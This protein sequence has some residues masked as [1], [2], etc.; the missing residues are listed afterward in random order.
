MNLLID[1]GNSS[2]KIALFT[3]NSFIKIFRI[4][5]L[6]SK[7]LTAVLDESNP[8]SCIIAT[9]KKL[10]KS[11]YEKLRTINHFHELTHQSNLPLTIKY[12]SPNTLGKDR[13]AAAVGAQTIFPD[14]NVLVIDFGTAITYDIITK[15][16]LYIGGNIAPGLNTRFRSLHTETDQLP[17]LHQTESFPVIGNNTNNAIISGVQTGIVFEIEGYINF[18]RHNYKGFKVIFTGGDAPFFVKMIKTTIF[19]EPNLIMIG[20]NKILEYND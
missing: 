3:N 5:T 6:D 1:Q 18:M 9:V 4:N 17:L 7:E 13:I 10:N 14:E 16:A 19:V 12:E 2:C 11:I 8:D 15:N 20:L